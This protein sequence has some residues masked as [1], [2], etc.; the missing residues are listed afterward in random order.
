MCAEYEENSEKNPEGTLD[1]DNCH[2]KFKLFF[3]YFSLKV[4]ISM[5]FEVLSKKKIVKESSR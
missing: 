4:G 2:F 3:Y 5:F 1:L